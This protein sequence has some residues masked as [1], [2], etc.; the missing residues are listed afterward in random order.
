MADA[1][2]AAGREHHVEKGHPVRQ[3]SRAGSSRAAHHRSACLI[4]AVCAPLA[5]TIPEPYLFSRQPSRHACPAGRASRHSRPSQ[6]PRRARRQQSTLHVAR[7][8]RRSSRAS[9]QGPSHDGEITRARTRGSNGVGER[10]FIHHRKVMSRLLRQRTSAR[11]SR[12]RAFHHTPPAA[13]IFCANFSRAPTLQHIVLPKRASCRAAACAVLEIAWEGEG[14][15]VTIEAT[16]CA[17]ALCHPL[18]RTSPVAA[19][20]PRRR[21]SPVVTLRRW[22]NRRPPELCA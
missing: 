19:A 16:R 17:A 9:A 18:S 12:R 3:I 5:P 2:G 4:G 13:H 10:A 7:A 15:G 1:C 11:L 8:L 21:Q 14:G 6:K 22:F 20:S